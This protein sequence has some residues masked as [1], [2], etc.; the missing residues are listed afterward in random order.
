MLIIDP[1][2]HSMEPNMPSTHPAAC[3]AAHAATPGKPLDQEH[4]RGIVTQALEAA[5][6]AEM[7]E[8]MYAA[9]AGSPKDH[10]EALAKAQCSVQQLLAAHEWLQRY[11]ALSSPH[12]AQS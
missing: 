8:L 3:L 12:T 7:N 5:F 9:V 4:L 1:D 2:A 11:E 6:R 10:R